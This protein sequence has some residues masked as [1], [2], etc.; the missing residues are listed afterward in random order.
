MLRR[1]LRQ[2]STVG[3]SS[4][5]MIF[6]EDEP[7]L[8]AP[9]GRIVTGLGLRWFNTGQTLRRRF[10][11]RKSTMI[12]PSTWVYHDLWGLTTLADLDYAE[13]RVG[14]LH[15]HWVG[16]EDLLSASGRLLDGILCVSAATVELARQCL[17]HLEAQRIQWIPYPVEPPILRAEAGRVQ[18]NELVVGYCGRIQRPQKRVERLPEI[19]R[20]LRAAGV[21]HRWEFLGQGPAQPAL[22]R[23]FAKIGVN[24]LFHGVQTGEAYWQRLAQW[25][26]IIF[27]SDYEGL[28]IALLEAL[29]QG[30]VPVFPDVDNGGRDYTR[31]IASKLVYPAGDVHAAAEA[32]KWFR[33]LPPEGRA[34]MRQQA[35]AA[36][37]PHGQDA[38]GRTF[39][40][41]LKA[42][43]AQP[44]ISASD[45][46]ARSAHP[47][48]WFPYGILGMLPPTHRLRKG[49]A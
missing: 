26:V 29:T 12:R 43:L 42:L 31:K 13:R 30:V 33:N 47:G 48:E 32:L 45:L 37:A 6:F 20:E 21:V 9:P 1:H 36:A 35:R 24:A 25:D 41:F 34:S 23:D 27:A 4:A 18:R 44:R 15:S 14:L 5:S 17:P 40:Q 19:A 2:D 49:Y 46:A 7:F 3:L 16:A 11:N 28:P 22:E 10:Q 38:Y 8:E 39:S